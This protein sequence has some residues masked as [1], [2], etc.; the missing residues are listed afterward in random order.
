VFRTRVASRPASRAECRRSRGTEGSNPSPSSGESSAN[1][2]SSIRVPIG[3]VSGG[4]LRR[5][6]G[7][8]GRRAHWRCDTRPALPIAVPPEISGAGSRDR[9]STVSASLWGDG[10]SLLRPALTRSIPIACLFGL[11]TG[12]LKLNTYAPRNHVSSRD[13]DFRSTRRR[14]FARRGAN[15]IV[16]F[17]K[18]VDNH[19]PNV[20]V[21]IDDENML[22]LAGHYPI[23]CG[24]SQEG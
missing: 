5:S 19:I 15:A 7:L 20:T 2:I 23:T 1:L 12:I 9:S 3:R 17:L 6:D 14:D 21:F 10:C 4:A 16:L 18:D 8:A 11:R 22:R 24:T 13:R